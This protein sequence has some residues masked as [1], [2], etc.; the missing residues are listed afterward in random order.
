MP[1][2]LIAPSSVVT[3]PA[4]LGTSSTSFGSPASVLV[5]PPSWNVSLAIGL[6]VAITFDC[7]LPVSVPFNTPV[8]VQRRKVGQA[9]SP[10]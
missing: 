7:E 1:S 4:E 5:A 3:P 8:T 9:A 10:L 2:V 6:S